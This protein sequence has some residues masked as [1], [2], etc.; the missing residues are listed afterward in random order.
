[1]TR[2]AMNTIP[3][4]IAPPIPETGVWADVADVVSALGSTLDARELVVAI[5]ELLSARTGC[6][7]EVFVFDRETRQLR[8]VRTGWNCEL[9]SG[10]AAALQLHTVPVRMEE[11]WN[12]T[13]SHAG[14]HALGLRDGDKLVGVAFIETDRIE[15]DSSLPVIAALSG[16]EIVRCSR[17][18]ELARLTGVSEHSRNLQ[19]QILDHVSHEFNTP[20]MILR[21]SADFAREASEEERELFFDMHGQALDRLEQL[22]TRKPNPGGL[23]PL[24]EWSRASQRTQNKAQ[25]S[26]RSFSFP[27]SRS[28]RRAVPIRCWLLTEDR[29]R[30]SW[31]PEETRSGGSAPSSRAGSRRSV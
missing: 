10:L 7:V 13:P 24:P 18:A 8:D 30:G 23:T 28:T 19:Q 14:G 16:A 4:P 25:L 1:M 2:M 3:H 17:F 22:G 12:A 9:H 29:P 21:S 31:L 15:A 20:L 26:M 27:L 6:A 5:R 11:N